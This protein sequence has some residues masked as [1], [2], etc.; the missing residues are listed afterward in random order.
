LIVS[1]AYALIRRQWKIFAALTKGFQRGEFLIG[2]WGPLN[3]L[4]PWVARRARRDVGKGDGNRLPAPA[5][6][7]RAL[8]HWHHAP[9][10]DDFRVLFFI[11]H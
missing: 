7:D 2:V 8:T 10:I 9:V 1:D 5:N 3:C 4:A 11:R 6:P